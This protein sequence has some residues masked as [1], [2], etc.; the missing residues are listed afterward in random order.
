MISFMSVF[1]VI[2]LSIHLTHETCNAV[3]TVCVHIKQFLAKLTGFCSS[4]IF[5]SRQTSPLSGPGALAWICFH[6]KESGPIISTFLSN[7]V[8]FWY[9]MNICIFLITLE[10]S[11]PNHILLGYQCKGDYT[12]SHHHFGS[13]VT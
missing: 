8:R 2:T 11:K 1:H 9:Q 3:S 6:L 5:A 4:L 10:V 13:D 12:A 7:F